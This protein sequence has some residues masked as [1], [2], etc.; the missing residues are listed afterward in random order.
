MKK[1]TVEKILEILNANIENA[2][3]KEDKLDEDLSALGMD[4]ITFIKIIVALE[5]EFECEIPDSKLLIGE[6]NTANKILQVLQNIE[7]TT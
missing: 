2:E 1:I 5:E 4:S 6:M 3:V 7:V